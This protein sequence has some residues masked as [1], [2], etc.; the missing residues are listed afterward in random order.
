MRTDEYR[1]T[2]FRGDAEVLIKNKVLTFP[3][4]ILNTDYIIFLFQ[5]FVNSPQYLRHNL[6]YV[7]T[8]WSYITMIT[9]FNE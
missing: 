5:I 3:A 4:K 1:S 9:K 2:A 8:V 6:W 7:H